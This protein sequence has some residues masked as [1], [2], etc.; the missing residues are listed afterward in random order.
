VNV[1][2]KFLI[3]FYGTLPD[4]AQAA[5]EAFD[6]MGD[7]ITEILNRADLEPVGIVNESFSIEDGDTE[8]DA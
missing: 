8:E 6:R 4:D 7:R 1:K 3:Q 5:D 2:A